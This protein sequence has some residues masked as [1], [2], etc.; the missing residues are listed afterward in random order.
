[1]MDFNKIVK[2]LCKRRWKLLFKDDIFEVIDPEKKENY[3]NFLDK[4]IYKL[5]AR[6]IIITIKSWV[7]VISEDE[8]IELNKVD[9]LDKYYL[10]L[11]KK[12][13]TK[14]VWNAYYLSGIKSLE[15]HL[16]N[17]EIPDKVFVVN[18]KSN[19]RVKIWKREIVFKTI[20]WKKLDWKNKKIN[21]YS[22]FSRFSVKKNIE[23]IQLRISGLELSLLESA[24]I[25]DAE[26]GFDIWLIIKVLKKYSQVLDTKILYRIWEYKYI[27][28]FNRL[29]ELSKE[30][31]WDLY[32][33]FLDII[34]KNGGLFIGEWARWI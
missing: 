7:Y 18:R 28:S 1:M 15:M 24:L 22:M 3:R 30:I 33:V 29:K 4:L 2:I 21:L 27:M 9:L 23:W 34:K 8:D 6:Q 10:K 5:K 13:I 11:L 20:S 19:K 12:I 25:S 32:V 14:E 17:Y 26:W 31:D 16:K